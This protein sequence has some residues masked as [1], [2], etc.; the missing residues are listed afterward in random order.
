LEEH[1][2]ILNK[3]I[4]QAQEEI[5]K[6][7]E[8]IIAYN[9]ILDRQR[10][11][12]EMELERMRYHD[13]R[14]TKIKSDLENENLSGDLSCIFL[15]KPENYLEF[16]KKL[17]EFRTNNPSQRTQKFM[18]GKEPYNLYGYNHPSSI[19]EIENCFDEIFNVNTKPF[20]TTFG[21]GYIIEDVLKKDEKEIFQY[22]IYPPQQ[23][24]ITP[25]IIQNDIDKNNYNNTIKDKI[26]DLYERSVSH[27]DASSRMRIIAV[28]SI[29]FWHFSLQSSTGKLPLLDK[30]IKD[31]YLFCYNEDNNLCFFA[32]VASL[33]CKNRNTFKPNHATARARELFK[34]YYKIESF[35]ELNKKIGE[36]KGVVLEYSTMKDICDHFKINLIIYEYRPIEIRYSY[37]RTLKYDDN[38]TDLHILEYSMDFDGKTYSHIMHILDHEKLTGSM[39]CPKC[40]EY[41]RDKSITRSNQRFNQHVEK[42]NGKKERKVKLNKSSKPYIPHINKSKLMRHQ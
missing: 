25:T 12:I 2:K 37:Q 13:R 24:L 29:A 10:Y 31:K 7:E 3:I 38:Y 11:D 5:R 26:Q 23:Q 21:L 20:K 6:N 34:D 8:E 36:F 9:R 28:I 18:P 35:K 27:E 39:I 33:R 32:A 22:R 30:F 4:Q 17:Q 19:Q 14:V 1:N 42:C 15:N 40:K 41:A 16:F